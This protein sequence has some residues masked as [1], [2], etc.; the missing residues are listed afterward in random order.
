[1]R[2]KIINFIIKKNYNNY[3]KLKTKEIKFK[4]E[5]LYTFITKFFVLIILAFIFKY[6]KTFLLL[7]FFMLPLRHF[8][9]GFHSKSNSGCWAITLIM[10]FIIPLITSRFIIPFNFILIVV[11][12]SISSIILFAPRST[13]KNPI[14]NK[15]RNYKRKIIVTFISLFYFWAIII[16]KNNSIKEIIALSLLYQGL[17]VNPITFYI[18]NQDF[19]KQNLK[20]INWF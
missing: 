12:V 14:S 15:K 2:E 6:Q 10:Y 3:S 7:V 16:I 5:C 18:F 17:L 1:M 11:T 9:F 4:L 8:G 19:K 20:Y 13:S